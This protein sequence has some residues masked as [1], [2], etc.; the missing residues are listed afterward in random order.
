MLRM[1]TTVF[2][3][4]RFT[5][6]SCGLIFPPLQEGPVLHWW[7]ACWGELDRRIDSSGHL[8][9]HCDRDD[10]QHRFLSH[11]HS[12]LFYSDAFSKLTL[13]LI[14]DIISTNTRVTTWITITKCVPV[15]R[16]SCCGLD[17]N[18]SPASTGSI[19]NART[20]SQHIPIPVYLYS[21]YCRWRVHL[22]WQGKNNY[23]TNF[24]Y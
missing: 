20:L 10:S 22:V 9:E 1:K 13:F 21:S 4:L 19:F 24:I 3:H 23:A 11:R 17:P 7:L 18:H 8:A 12:R 15:S 16:M 2:S 14:P 6:V 5:C